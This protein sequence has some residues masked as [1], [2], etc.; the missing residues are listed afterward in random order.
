MS[1]LQAALA[2]PVGNKPANASDPALYEKCEL[3]LA[4][5]AGKVTGPQ[6]AAVLGISKGDANNRC[7]SAIITGI[8]TGIV[9]VTLN[10]NH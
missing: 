8:R 1:L 2:A 3:A 10:G 5:L 7:A 4:Y 6:V 9:S